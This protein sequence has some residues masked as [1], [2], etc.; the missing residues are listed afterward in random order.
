MEADRIQFGLAGIAHELKSRLLAVPIYQRSYAWTADELGDFWNDLRAEFSESA[1]E[2]FLGTLVLTRQASPPRDTIIDGQQRLATT[3]VLLAAIRDEFIARH[4]KT[5][6]D[7]VQRDYLSTSDLA[8]ATEISRLTLN[9][10]DAHFFE[11]RIVNSDIAVAPS[12]PSH[13]LLVA[14]Y[15][16]FRR[17]I[18]KVADDA[19]PDWATRL[20]QWVE[21][22]KGKSV[23]R[24]WRRTCRCWRR[25]ASR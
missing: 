13:H 15:E 23:R 11:R 1:P 24:S 10:E 19:G 7:I 9:S 8:S 6:A 4:D 3:S 5:R 2:Y 12:R 22:L 21:F 18:K 16:H 14:A 17:E 20:T 25:R